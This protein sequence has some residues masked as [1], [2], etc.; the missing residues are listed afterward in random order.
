MLDINKIRRFVKSGKYE[1]TLH[2]LKRLDQRQ[3]LISEVKTAIMKGVIVESY[4][5]DR[6]YPSCL[7]MGKVRGGF[8]L[9]VVCAQGH[10]KVYIITVHW[11]DPA[12]WLDPTTRREKK[13]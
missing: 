3:I 13:S 9:Y 1:I 2:A 8:P 7:V 11:L 12:K 5:A 6:P 10:D 4:P